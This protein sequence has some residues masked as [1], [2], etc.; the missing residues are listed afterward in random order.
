MPAFDLA[1]LPL[2]APHVAPAGLRWIDLIGLG[3]LTLFLVLGAMR[4]LWWQIIR[5]LGIVASVSVARALAPRLSPI[6]QNA[7]PGLSPSIANGLAWVALLLAGLVVISMIGRIGRATLKAAQLGAFDRIGGALAGLAS[8]FLV[9]LALL[10]CLCQISTSS[11]AASAV[12][13]T[14][15]QDLLDAVGAHFPMIIDARAAESIQ[16]MHEAPADPR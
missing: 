13:G 6:L 8:G 9:H 14:R 11:W 7:L 2:Q 15:S 10:L 1:S 5:L 3:I 12:R 16:H 4:G